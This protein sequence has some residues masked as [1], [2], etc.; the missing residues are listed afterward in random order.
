MLAVVQTH[1]IQYHAPVYRLVQERWG[2]PVTAIYGSDFSIAGYRDREFG[3]TFAWDSD[4]LSGYSSEFLAR[5]ANGGA[6]EF[7]EVSARGVGTALARLRPSAV[8]IGGYSPH[9]HRAAFANAL[10]RGYPVLFRGETI[11]GEP[12]RFFK[13]SLRRS[14][15]RLLYSRCARLLYIGTRSRRHFEQHGCAQNRLVFSP[16]C[17]DATSFQTDEVAR[18][19]LRTPLRRTL[20]IADED[21]LILFS[22]KLTPKKRPDLLIDATRV[23]QK[24]SPR[25]VAV[26]FLGDGE[27]RATL[28][29]SSRSVPGLMT[30]FA[31]FKNQTQLS[32]YYHAADV[33][34]L[35]SD[36][37]ETW[38]VVVNEA[39]AHGVP[40]VVSDAVGCAPDL[41]RPGETGETFEIG[42]AAALASAILRT[43]ALVGTLETRNR[44]RHVANLF[45]VE[46]AAAGI[47]Q[48]YRSVAG[49]SNSH[50]SGLD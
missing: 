42:S 43:T 13:R 37:S 1:P 14:A 32:A 8:L 45:S 16:Y 21:L 30:H 4:L 20:G 15:L 22:G 11:D 31:G 38:G 48:A 49:S 34:V 10:F 47:A 24:A 2:V 33:L 5:V 26:I 46:Q 36:H 35:P 25:R 12:A 39:L 7:A 19:R 28:E 29:A 40:C 3:T 50:A 27:L 41:A 18:Q 9:F 44:C 23:M 6:S 17:T